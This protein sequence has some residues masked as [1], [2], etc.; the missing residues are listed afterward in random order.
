ME[1]DSERL[2]ELVK[3]AGSVVGRRLDS[4]G[5]VVERGS[6]SK[7]LAIRETPATPSTTY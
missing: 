3:K 6:R 2:D 7:L 4:L 5:T 1:Q